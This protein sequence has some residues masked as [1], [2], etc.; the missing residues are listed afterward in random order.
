MQDERPTAARD[1]V[2]AA[3]TGSAL[4]GGLGKSTGPATAL[5]GLDRGATAWTTAAGVT[6]GKQ[7]ALGQSIGEA[8]RPD[9]TLD[10]G[11]QYEPHGIK[12]AACLAGAD[13][14]T[15]PRVERDLVGIDVPDPGHL[16]LVHQDHLDGLPAADEQSRERRFIERRVQRIGAE[17]CLRFEGFGT[18]NSRTCPMRRGLT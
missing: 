11:P 13:A 2:P 9:A 18:I 8:F 16:C 17:R 15:Q 6:L 10:C 1:A 14:R 5:D 7:E 12:Q 4:V 3:V